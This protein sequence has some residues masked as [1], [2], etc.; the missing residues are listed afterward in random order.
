MT[1]LEVGKFYYCEGSKAE[2][3]RVDIIRKEFIDDPDYIVCTLWGK[4]GR[5]YTGF[6]DKDNALFNC[7][8]LCIGKVT[9]EYHEPVKYSVDIFIEKT[10][11]HCPSC[12]TLTKYILGDEVFTWDKVPQKDFK[13]YRITVEEIES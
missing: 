6:V 11:K 1:K 9:G 3:L 5:A 2:Y 7:R 4:S 10:P 13:K 12:C 8:G